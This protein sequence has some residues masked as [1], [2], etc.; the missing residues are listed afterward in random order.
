MKLNISD[1]ILRKL[2][3]LIKSKG[4]VSISETEKYIEG[5]LEEYINET[6][7]EKKNYDWCWFDND[8][9]DDNFLN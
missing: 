1:E 9:C 2:H 3:P 4:F 5:L 8:T 6:A 7:E